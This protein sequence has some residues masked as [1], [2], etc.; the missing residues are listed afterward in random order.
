[1]GGFEYKSEEERK[2]PAYYLVARLLY[3]M[4]E[5]FLYRFFQNVSIFA[6][7]HRSRNGK[8]VPSGIGRLCNWTPNLNGPS[9]DSYPSF[10]AY[11]RSLTLKC[12]EGEVINLVQ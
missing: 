6:G 10:G 11:Q 4:I 9:A 7:V 1:M 2:V 12:D 5:K 8:V 3:L